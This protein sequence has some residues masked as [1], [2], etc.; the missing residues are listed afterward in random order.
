MA[1]TVDNYWQTTPESPAAMMLTSST[2]LD[3]VITATI[4][5][6]PTANNSSMI[7]PISDPDISLDSILNSLLSDPPIEEQLAPA[8]T[9]T[10]SLNCSSPCPDSRFNSSLTGLG[11]PATNNHTAFQP[12]RLHLLSVHNR[13]LQLQQKFQKLK[14]IYPDQIQQLSSFYRYQSALVETSRFQ[15]LHQCSLDPF[16]YNSLNSYY[17][18]Q[19]DLIID[20]VE[21]H[22]LQ[23]E[24]YVYG[25]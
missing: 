10:W 3:D 12:S 6:N 16:N 2:T 7:A 19:L 14:F 11:S 1:D 25:V 20:R 17:D 18:N 24:I 13:E 8:K 5:D 22:N 15:C 21:V 4:L 9:H 23:I